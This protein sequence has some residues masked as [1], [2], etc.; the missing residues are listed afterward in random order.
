MKDL[1]KR[2]F[3]YDE[4]RPLQDEIISNV[5]SGNDSLVI[6]PTGGG[7][8]LCYQLPALRLEGLTLVVSPLIALMKDQVDGLQAM[9]INAEYINSTL[10]RQE[11]VRIQQDTSRGKVKILYVAP[12]RLVLDG[13]QRFLSQL[14]VS[15][16]A[17]DEAH[18]ISEW[19][20]DFRPDYRSLGELRSKMPTVPFIALT[21]TATHRVRD[22]IVAQL[23]LKSPQS[24]VASFNRENLNYDVRPKQRD[25][26]AQ[27]IDLLDDHRGQSTIV[28]CFSRKETEQLASE[29]QNHGHSARAYHAG[30]DA[31]TRR[32]NQEGFINDQFSIVVATIA[33]G[34]GIDKPDVRLVVHFSLPKSLESYYQETGRAG[35]DGLPSDCVLFYSH[36]DRSK[37]EF[38]INKTEDELERQNASAKLQIVVDFC[39]LQSC[40]RRY[41][42]EYFGDDSITDQVPD[43]TNC[44]GCDNCL[45][46]HEEFDATVITQKILSAI[47]R[48]GESFGVAHVNG[49]LLGSRRKK[50]LEKGHDSLSV[51]GIVN[52]FDRNQLREIVDS[53]ALKG[54]VNR[55]DDQYSTLSVSVQGRKILN[56][57][58]RVMLRRPAE[59][60]RQSKQLPAR[61]TR[62][63]DNGLFEQLR[64]LR[65]QI[66]REQGVPAYVV[67]SDAALKDM[68]HRVPTNRDE[69][70]LVSGVGSIKLE[71][72]GDQFL[73]VIQRYVQSTSRN[74]TLRT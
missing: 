5:L 18:C 3:G 46:T 74:E 52:D 26:K 54:L 25:T 71:Q 20:H 57:R 6:M 38:F 72:Y 22:D 68:A 33:F 4:F 14:R 56:E 40:R 44:Q 73:E 28:Y 16:V 12:E 59:S 65:L 50:V 55:S 43:E 9:G 36:G 13:F 53:L 62:Q 15:L 58:R 63:S 11:F 1:L 21:A 51:Y 42:L 61:D 49:V 10:P 34:M 64:Q 17:V 7:K 48:T 8:S 31:D 66:S 41:L 30:M 35:R 69:F 2:Y 19:G 67:F 45:I 29:L 27:L 37:Q 60:R 70:G 47:I 39:Q 24:F 32:E 23:G